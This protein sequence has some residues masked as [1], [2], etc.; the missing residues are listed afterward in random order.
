MDSK[1]EYCLDKMLAAQSGNRKDDYWGD[2]LARLRAATT[3]VWMAA[4][5]DDRTVV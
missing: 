5:R 1:M 4:Q 2:Y 3:A